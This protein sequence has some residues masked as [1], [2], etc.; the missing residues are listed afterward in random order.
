[1]VGHENKLVTKKKEKNCLIKL[2]Y[3]KCL[4]SFKGTVSVILSDPPCKVGNARFT[5]VPLEAF[6]GQV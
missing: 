1:M 2:S 4:F 3:Q 5:R 6:S